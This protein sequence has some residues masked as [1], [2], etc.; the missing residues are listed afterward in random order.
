M[1]SDA[2]R[3]LDD[4]TPRNI[5]IAALDC[6]IALEEIAYVRLRAAHRYL[7]PE[8]V[9][10]WQPAKVLKFLVEDIDPTILGARKVSISAQRLPDG[11]L[12]ST[13]EDYASLKYEDLFEQSAIQLKRLN[14]LWQKMGKLLHAPFPLDEDAPSGGNVE[15]QITQIR[16]AIEFCRTSS[17]SG[18][19]ATGDT[20]THEFLCSKGHRTNRLVSRLKDGQWIPCDKHG[21][22]SAFKIS[23]RGSQITY[24]Q[25]TLDIACGDCGAIHSFPPEKFTNLSYWEVGDFECE[26]C[27][28]VTRVQWMLARRK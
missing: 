17:G 5:R 27:K 2:E 23:R 14:K 3:L 15:D 11:S 16:E 21:C 13:P 25:I 28:A 10:E 6:R 8:D 1:L 20:R 24:Q 18:A 9:V 7:S 26:K 22:M 19:M 4:P 12:P